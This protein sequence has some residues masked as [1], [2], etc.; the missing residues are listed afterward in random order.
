MT[1]AMTVVARGVTILDEYGPE[2]WHLKITEPV[3][4]LSTSGCPLGQIYGD[5]FSEEA[6][7]LRSGALSRDS[8]YYGFDGGY[9]DD[10]DGKDG[11]DLVNDAWN[12]VV[13]MRNGTSVPTEPTFTL[14]QLR[15]MHVQGKSL[16]TLLDEHTS[17][18]FNLTERQRELIARAVDSTYGSY[19]SD[20]TAIKRAIEFVG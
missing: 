2:D 3:N 16:N 9:V 19:D 6:I 5:Y 8:S 12:A 10:V 7:D 15:E 18:P 17:K 20:S 11:N 4:V 14:S 13:A 1:E